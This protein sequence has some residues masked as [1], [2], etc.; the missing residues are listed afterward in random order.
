MFAVEEMRSRRRTILVCR[1][2]CVWL[3]AVGSFVPLLICAE[4]AQSMTRRLKARRESTR[5]AEPPTGSPTDLQINLVNA[6]T[7][8]ARL[9]RKHRTRDLRVTSGYGGGGCGGW[10]LAWSVRPGGGGGAKSGG[11]PGKG[12]HA[13]TSPTALI[14]ARVIQNWSVV[15]AVDC[16]HRAREKWRLGSRGVNQSEVRPEICCRRSLNRGLAIYEGMVLR[17]R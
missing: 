17:G 5:P 1:V 14:D 8:I 13:A 7:S 12:S 4:R 11:E 9:N 10:G 3:A 16:A 15:I 2:S 6:Q